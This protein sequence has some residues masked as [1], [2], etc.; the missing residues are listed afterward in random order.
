MEAAMADEDLYATDDVVNDMIRDTEREIFSEAVN[1]YE[2]DA[3]NQIIED[4]SQAEGWDGFPLS[5]AE[6]GA[7]TMQAET[8]VNFDRPL[9]METE[10][11]LAAERDALRQERDAWAAAYQRDA[12]TPQTEAARQQT[13][14]QV[15][16]KLYNEYGVLLTDPA[17]SDR[18]LANEVE[19]QALVQTLQT[20]RIN[21]SFAEAHHRYGDE[22]AERYNAFVRQPVDAIS[23]AIAHRFANA[24]D[25]GEAFMQLT[26]GNLTRPPPFMP[27]S[28]PYRHLG[29][30]PRQ[31]RARAPRDGMGGWGDAFVEDDIFRSAFDDEGWG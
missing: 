13:R 12:M 7:R 8:G 30:S 4:L 10:Q 23:S 28:S 3:S 19:K 26:D 2:D 17:K 15:E 20:D 6:I 16:D 14:Q 22:F 11:T 29:P 21:Q 9:Q 27:A 24:E 25:P 18:F 5:D 1:G 31:S